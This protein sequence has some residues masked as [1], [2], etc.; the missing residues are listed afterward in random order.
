MP[1]IDQWLEQ[2]RVTDAVSRVISRGHREALDADGNLG[3]ILCRQTIGT[4]PLKR[5][6]S[7]CKADGR[8]YLIAQPIALVPDINA[9]W[10]HTLSPTDEKVLLPQVQSFLDTMGFPYEVTA[11]GQVYLVLSKPPL[12]SFQPL[13]RLAGVSLD[14]V[15]P[16]GEEAGE[17]VGYISESQIAFHQALD[18]TARGGM[19]LGLWFWGLGYLPPRETLEPRVRE[20]W[21][22]SDELSALGSWLGLEVHAFDGL[23]KPPMRESVLID[24]PEAMDDAALLDSVD[25]YIRRVLWRLRWGV[26]KRFELASRTQKWSLTTKDL[27][28]V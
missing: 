16:K 3:Q 12:V 6:A 27:W 7:G 28:W 1:K 15:M 14:Q 25:V 8:T 20:L 24:W 19:G 11:E 26:L 23:S 5:V 10:A 21:A 9:V 13:W 22:S 18:S 4:A 17:W 2:N